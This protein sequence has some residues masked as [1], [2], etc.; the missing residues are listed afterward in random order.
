MPKDLQDA[1]AAGRLKY[2]ESQLLRRVGDDEK[3]L[4]LLER[5]VNKELDTNE[6]SS[7]VAKA[8]SSKAD[9]APSYADQ[10]RQRLA[11]VNRALKHADGLAARDK[12]RL[13]KAL[14]VIENLLITSKEA[15]R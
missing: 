2:S 5:A 8:R 4:E 13:E 3:R 15:A 10:V 7:E 9:A 14:G 6:L 11:A 1:L 12:Q